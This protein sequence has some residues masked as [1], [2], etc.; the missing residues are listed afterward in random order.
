ML[1]PS[2]RVTACI[3]PGAVLRIGMRVLLQNHGR[4]PRGESYTDLIARL[5]PIAHEM[6]RQREPLLIVAHQ[7]PTWDIG[8]ACL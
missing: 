4:Y 8:T 3:I 7:V 1:L 2:S 6:E 5:E